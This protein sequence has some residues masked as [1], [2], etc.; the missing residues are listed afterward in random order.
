MTILFLHGWESTPGGKKPSFFS[1]NGHRVLNPP[2]PDDDFDRAV[3]VAQTAFD[4]GQPQLV[5][6]SSRGGAVA[7]NIDSHNVPLLLICPAWK[8]WGAT[9]AA[10]PNAIILHSPTDEIIPF[11]QSEE[12]LAESPSGVELVAFG[13]DHRMADPATLRMM[14]RLGERL[15]RSSAS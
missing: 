14:L 9:R 15:V 3:A 2:L 5:V 13:S 4:E 7:L 11:A 8:K 6:G 12:L 10:K 1:E